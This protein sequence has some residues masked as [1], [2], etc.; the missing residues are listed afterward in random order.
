MS[1]LE[2][3]IKRYAEL[4]YKANNEATRQMYNFRACELIVTY[5]AQKDERQRLFRLFQTLAMQ[6]KYQMAG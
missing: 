2:D 1:L 6:D 4:Y 3:T 5:I